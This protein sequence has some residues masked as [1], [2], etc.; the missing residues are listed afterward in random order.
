M[1]MKHLTITPAAV[2]ALIACSQIPEPATGSDRSRESQSSRVASSADV[3]RPPLEQM[4]LARPVGKIGV[5]VDV[6]YLVSGVIAK[7]QPATVQ[8]A[9]VPRVAGSNLQVQFPDTAGVTIDAGS[10]ELRAQKATTTDVLRHSVLV[11]PTASDSGE[12][13]AIVSMDFDGGRYFSIFT[14]PVGGSS[15]A[16]AKRVPKD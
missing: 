11:T 15:E 14:I 4:A 5:P 2:L 7:D 1:A 3:P 10:R 6:R 12:M 13:R 8:L 16:A 9:F